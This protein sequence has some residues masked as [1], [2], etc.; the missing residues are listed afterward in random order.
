[1]QSN[2]TEVWKDIPGYE[3]FYQASSKGRIRSVSRIVRRKNGFARW[4]GKILRPAPSTESGHLV[5]RLSKLGKAEMFGVHVLILMAFV[6]PC[7][8]GMEGCHGDGRPGNNSIDNLRWDTHRNNQRDMQKH[9]TANFIKGERH[10]NAKLSDEQA[11]KI[12]QLRKCGWGRNQLAKK[13]NV[14]G[15]T[16]HNIVYGQGRFVSL[17]Q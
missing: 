3:G 6:G 14:T 17:G 15:G 2:Y 8:K 11:L 5:V 7:P 9:G 4:S 12:R 16:I 10:Q 1:M 13:F